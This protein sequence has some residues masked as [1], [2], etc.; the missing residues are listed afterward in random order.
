MNNINI[1]LK[2]ILILALFVCAFSFVLFGFSKK[3]YAY[4]WEQVGQ[5]NITSLSGVTGNYLVIKMINFNNKLFATTVNINLVNS[6]DIT[7]PLNIYTPQLW[8]TSDGSTW[9]QATSFP[10]LEWHFVTGSPN[11]YINFILSLSGLSA[12]EVYNGNLFIPRTN[13][14]TNKAALY[15]SSDGLTW[16]LIF[17][18]GFGDSGNFTIS[19]LK[20]FNNYLY[21]TTGNFSGMQIWRSQNGTSGWEKVSNNGMGDSNNWG[22]VIL[23]SF[24]NK[25]YVGTINTTSGAEIWSSA[26]GTTWTQSGPDGLGSSSNVATLNLFNFNNKL[27]TFLAD[28][29]TGDAHVFSTTDGVT[30]TSV[31]LSGYGAHFL[32]VEALIPIMNVI[33]NNT[34]W[35]GGANMPSTG[36]VFSSSDLLS[37]TQEGSA[38]F[39]DSGNLAPYAM[40]VFNN[41]IYVAYSM[42]I[43]SG[44]KL[45]RSE[46]IPS[47]SINDGLLTYGSLL[48]SGI[49]GESYNYSFSLN[50]GT[51]P[52]TFSCPS[53]LPAGIVLSSSG[54]LSGTP[55][56]AGDYSCNI[57]VNDS[58]NPTLSYTKTYRLIINPAATVA[59]LPETGN[60]SLIK[61][62]ILIIS[63]AASAMLAQ[64]F[65][66]KS[67]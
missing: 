15:K 64:K 66:K 22:S 28:N 55:T 7:D 35:I 29:N 47:F 40:T 10:S 51:P 4:S 17:D 43:N 42:N 25:L 60:G 23:N 53:G 19:E 27:Y 63:I 58:G 50:N 26:D 62:L 61:W 45:Y 49:V 67:I 6:N 56:A 59:I 21:A 48:P 39:G 36:N 5:G 1:N 31:A 11:D 44:V 52:Y 12:M 32:D 13:P 3:T 14:S 20:Q 2:R 24:N 33:V 54:T 57:S 34:F 41:R 8:Y 16:D 65:Q 9:T 37:M 46:P 38:G 30:W 18:N